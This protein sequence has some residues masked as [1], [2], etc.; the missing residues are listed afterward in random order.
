MKLFLLSSLTFILFS[1]CRTIT[2]LQISNESKSIGTITMEYEYRAHEKP[3][4]QWVAA[5]Q[6]AIAKC[7]SWG[8]SGAKFFD[9]DSITCVEVNDFGKCI[10]WRVT[11]KCQCTN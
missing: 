4:V 3:H 5:Q 1:G 7:K 9:A 6:S 11:Y 10:R 8:Y 2:Y